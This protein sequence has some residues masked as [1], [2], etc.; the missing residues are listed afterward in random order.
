M[1]IVINIEKKHFYAMI[2]AISLLGGGLVLA[3]NSGGTGGAPATMGHSFDEMAGGVANLGDV[4]GIAVKG[5]QVKGTTQGGALMTVEDYMPTVPGAAAL[6]VRGH[7]TANKAIGCSADG[8]SNDHCGDVYFVTTVRSVP[9][10]VTPLPLCIEHNPADA[11][12]DGRI[13]VC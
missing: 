9:P 7:L 8:T 4:N 1:Q 3:Y 11:A 10:S 2:L 6:Q 5:F 13:V 12:N